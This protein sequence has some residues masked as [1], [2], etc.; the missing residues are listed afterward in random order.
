MLL[1]MCMPDKYFGHPMKSYKHFWCLAVALSAIQ[2]TTFISS[3][4]TVCQKQQ[5]AKH[6]IMPL[7]P[8]QRRNCNGLSHNFPQFFFT[9]LDVAIVLQAIKCDCQELKKPN[10][11]Q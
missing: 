3:H 1:E 6:T 7:R 9:W 5:Q 11:E 8:L 10:S 4:C 2:C